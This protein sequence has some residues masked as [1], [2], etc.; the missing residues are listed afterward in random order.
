VES[1]NSH[2]SFW[3]HSLIPVLIGALVTGGGYVATDWITGK[4][5][6][7]ELKSEIR[8]NQEANARLEKRLEEFS[9]E[10]TDGFD[11]VASDVEEW[12]IDIAA[13]LRDLREG[14]IMIDGKNLRHN[15]NELNNRVWKVEHDI[16]WFHGPG[17]ENRGEVQ[18]LREQYSRKRKVVPESDAKQGAVDGYP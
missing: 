10:I 3:N 12:K 15:V 14:M 5:Q 8:I 11:R 9:L 4:V 18:E 2:G 7:T 1:E 13:E 17:G 16:K 6:F